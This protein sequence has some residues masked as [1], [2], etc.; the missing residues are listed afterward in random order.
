[1]CDKT[2]CDR[3]GDMAPELVFVMRSDGRTWDIPVVFGLR[4]CE[5]CRARTK[6]PED[7]LTHETRDRIVHALVEARPNARHERTKLRWIS[8]ESKA[9]RMVQPAS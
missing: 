2:G 4:I 6:G 3:R 9:F 5:Q 1:M 8:C 7:F